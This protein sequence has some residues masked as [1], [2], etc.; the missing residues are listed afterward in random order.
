MPGVKDVVSV[1]NDNGRS[2]IQKRL[3]LLNLK[4][5]HTTFTETHP[6][7]PVSFSKFAQLRP[8]HCILAG[9]SGTHS[10]CVCTIHENCKLLLDSINIAKLT[11]SS[12]YPIVDYKDC[13]QKTCK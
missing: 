5:L 2:L 12:N 13:L 9:A 8:K 11:A 4:G 7:F 6:E 3:L 10:V 1:K